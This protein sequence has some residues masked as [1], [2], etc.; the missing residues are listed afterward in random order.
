MSDDE[1]PFDVL[2]EHQIQRKVVLNPANQKLGGQGQLENRLDN[3][4]RV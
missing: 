2:D 3:E 1:K 4:D